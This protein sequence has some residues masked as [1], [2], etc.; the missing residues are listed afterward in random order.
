MNTTVFDI[1]TR[2]RPHAEL[3]SMIPKFSAPSNYKDVDKISA[4]IAE[5]TEKWIEKAALS[6]LSGEII[7]IG[8]IDDGEFAC[9]DGHGSEKELLEN[10]LHFVKERPHHTFIGWN[11]FG[12]DIDFLHKRALYHSV[13]SCYSH[14]FDCYRQDRWIDLEHIWNGYNRNEHTSLNTVSRFLK[15]GEKTGEG[16]DFAAL[17]DKEKGAALAYLKTDCLLVSAIGE[18]MGL[19]EKNDTEQLAF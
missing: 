19:I 2:P 6:P 5:Q 8:V 4:N 10:W 7:C 18:R 16:K 17:W 12:F 11:I 9:L 13:K 1:E 14:S 15:V 3:A